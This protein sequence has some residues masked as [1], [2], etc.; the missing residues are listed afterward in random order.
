M[1]LWDLKKIV[2]LAY[3]AASFLAS[4]PAL[5]E[6]HFNFQ[7][8]TDYNAIFQSIAQNN[9]EVRARV[10]AEVQAEMLNL[11]QSVKSAVTC[12]FLTVLFVL[13]LFSHL[14]LVGRAQGEQ[15]PSPERNSVQ[16]KKDK[17]LEGEVNAP[18]F[19]TDLEWLNTERRLSL[20]ELRGKV[21]LLDFWTYCCINCM[22]IIP[23]LKKLEAKYANQL[24]VIGVHS[25]KFTT[26]KGTENIRQ[27]VL[28]YE[29]EHPVINDRDFAVW[30]SYAARAWP[31]LVLINPKGRVI[32]SHSGE[33][34]YEIF[35]KAIGQTID[36]FRAQG[37]MNEKPITFRLEKESAPP[38]LLSFPGKVLADEKSGRLFISDSNH[39][40]IIVASLDGAIQ[41]VIGDGEIGASDGTFAEAEFNHPQGVA[42]DGESLYICDTENHLIR[43]ADL[44]ARTVETLV[45]TG[46]QALRFNES[47][48]GTSVALNSPW[49][50][51]VH[52]GMLYV[53]MAGPH[54]LWV[55]D[56]KT[57]AARPY[58]GSGRENHTDGTLDQAALAQP[59][60][61][62]TDGQSIFFADSEVSSIRAASL[63]PG[64]T[65]STIVGQGL[66]DYGDTD[67]VG[68]S[69]RL[70]HP[71]GVTY[72]GGKLY[73][74]DTYNH[75]I[76]ELQIRQRESRTYAGTQD[77]GLR[78]GERR[79][80]RFNEPGGISSTSR[81]LF[82]ADT[83]NHL[84]RRIDLAKGTVT[85]V[86][87][88]GLERL[89]QHVTRRFRGRPVKLP[90]VTL[91]PGSSSVA[92]SFK[93]PAGYKY[94][95][96]APFYVGWRSKDATML[97]PATKENARSFNEPRF[98]FEIP[99]EARSG[100]TVF[101]I[102]A[103]VYF[104]NDLQDKVCLVDRVSI[105]LPVEVK[106]G[107]KTQAS[108]EV[109][110]GL[111]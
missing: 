57:R 110:A 2:Q 4:H 7:P 81:E 85:T 29:I 12:R 105:D 111:K 63:P 69:V 3:F 38:S 68:D 59:S 64:N 56:P 49:D 71:L 25:A 40:R 78:D 73:V 47:G 16:L 19:P 35:D 66:F 31:T 61:V 18:D 67:G 62:T 95:Q 101:T 97:R 15:S 104:C 1:P 92:L 106:A 32:G 75:K 72:T 109:V 84:I 99:V 43:R 107:G 50:A 51:L 45:G 36:Y 41:D 83:N 24:V 102:E 86:E 93:L 44:K 23:D 65:V 33:G 28:R 46:Q 70:Q 5:P 108:I 79:Q 89:N 88:K 80:A 52:D 90:T 26:E 13:T 48:I 17:F 10:Q 42:L 100:T 82:I 11:L 96:G 91:A 6:R 103:I 39:N 30:Q 54:Q 74:A 58:A 9:A 76:K 14:P 55:I 21:V 22:H 37:V 77:R 53:A 60:G 94:N 87:L 34:I 27:A 8:A 98:P 20:R